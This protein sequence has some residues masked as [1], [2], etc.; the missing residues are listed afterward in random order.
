MPR[1]AVVET[2]I[3]DEAS[4]VR[5]LLDGDCISSDAPVGTLRPARRRQ[6]SSIVEM[7]Y[8]ILEE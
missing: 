8:K 4:A 2:K 1:R 3:M 5:G 6:P 7:P